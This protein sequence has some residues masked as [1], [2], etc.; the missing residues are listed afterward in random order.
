M[1]GL[2]DIDQA[3]WAERLVDVCYGAVSAPNP[4][5]GAFLTFAEIR[6]FLGA[7]NI[8]SPFTPDEKAALKGGLLAALV[9]LLGDL[10]QFLDDGALNVMTEDLERAEGLFADITQAPAATLLEQGR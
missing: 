1:T 6:A 7:Y 2:L 10:V 4:E 8:P 9:E 5:V 3:T